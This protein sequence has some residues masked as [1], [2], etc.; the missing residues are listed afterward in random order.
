MTLKMM[1]CKKIL[2]QSYSEMRASSLMKMMVLT[3]LSVKER[4][5]VKDQ[6]HREKRERE[7]FRVFRREITIKYEEVYEREGMYKKK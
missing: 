1:E 6:Q 2:G 7:Y 4:R 5:R 3:C